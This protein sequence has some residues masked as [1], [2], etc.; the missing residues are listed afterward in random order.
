VTDFSDPSWWPTPPPKPPKAV[1]A[2]KLVFG[3]LFPVAIGV[4]ALVL[5]LTNKHHKKPDAAAGRSVAAFTACMKQQGADSPSVQAN[6]RILRLDA[7]ACKDHLPKGVQLPDFSEPAGG[8]QAGGSAF[9]QCMQSAYVNLRGSARPGRFGG[10]SS[11]K[12][13]QDAVSLCRSLTERAGA[14]PPQ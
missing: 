1:S 12:A 6:T 5:L 2:P 9:Q 13:F 11:R 8:G 3:T 14:A 4:V 7:I 10:G